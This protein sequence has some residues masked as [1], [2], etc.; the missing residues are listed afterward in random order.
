MADA[1]AEQS[2]F[3]QFVVPRIGNNSTQHRDALRQSTPEVPK[4][5]HSLAESPMLVI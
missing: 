3:T 1:L 4:L 5:T 2:A